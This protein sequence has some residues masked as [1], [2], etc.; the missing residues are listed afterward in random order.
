MR[1]GAGGAPR[2][3]AAIVRL[4]H[5][6][7]PRLR[8]PTPPMNRLITKSRAA[9]TAMT[10]S[11]WI[12]K[13]TPKKMIAKMASRTSNAIDFPPLG[14]KR[15]NPALGCALRG[16]S[17]QRLDHARVVGGVLAAEKRLGAAADRVAQVLELEAVRV[18]ALDLDSLH[19]AVAAELDHRAPGVPRVV[20]EERALLA[21]RLE[22]VARRQDEPAVDLAEDVVGEAEGPGERDVDTARAER[23]LAV[24]A[25]GL[26]RQQTRAADA[27]APDVHERAALEV[28]QQADIL[29]VVEE[30]AE[31]GPD[32]PQPADRALG[33]ELGQPLRLRRVTP[34]ERL[35]QQPACVLGG[36]EGVLGIGGGSRERLLA[37]HVLAG[38]ERADRPRH[39]ERVRQRDVDRL[40]VLI[41][42]EPLVAPVRALDPPLAR[43]RVGAG[44]VAARDRDEV[45]LRRG[46][47]RR[48][49]HAVDVRRREDSP[50]DGIGHREATASLRPLSAERSIASTTSSQR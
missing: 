8:P 27:V 3:L 49:D 17:V 34:H 29:R 15:L 38:L 42:E 36:V 6:Q 11:Q 25:L 4:V 47:R 16:R 41:L 24:H 23:L 19:L 13:P 48:D 18:R 28:G 9:I 7:A 37:Q 20:E 1:R 26:A 32:E 21:D 43:V 35:H 45:D 5:H 2:E 12:V 30:E 40:D 39:V 50:A 31:G 22:L 14:R 10:N 33:D 44:L 46:L